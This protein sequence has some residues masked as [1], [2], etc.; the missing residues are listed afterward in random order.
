MILLDSADHLICKHED[1][2]HGESSRAEVEEIL[3]TGPEKIHDEDIVVP[4]L[5]VPPDVG[6]A[7]SAL[8]DFVQF[9]LIQQLGVSR[10][11]A[12][13]LDGDLLSVGDVDA[14]VDVS[15][16]AGADLPDQS[17]L[18]SDYELGAGGRRGARHAQAAHQ[19]RSNIGQRD[20]IFRVIG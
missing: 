3:E 2:L 20:T 18:S 17:V 7:H 1:S 9:A 12:L 14:E 11:H 8:Q 6:D 5:A 4:L 16:T 10:L 13:Q 19:E 15:E